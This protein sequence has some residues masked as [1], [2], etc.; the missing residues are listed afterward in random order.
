MAS[1]R[2]WARGRQAVRDERQRGH[3]DAPLQLRILKTFWKLWRSS[4][5]SRLY[6]SRLDA[7]RSIAGASPHQRDVRARPRVPH[8]SH[9]PGDAPAWA[10]PIGM[11]RRTLRRERQPSA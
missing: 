1:I 6:A 10:R 4:I 7:R 8:L 11:T 3:E 5:K 2:A 9:R